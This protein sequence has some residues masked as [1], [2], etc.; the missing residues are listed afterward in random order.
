MAATRN[1]VYDALMALLAGRLVPATVKTVT[2]RLQGWATTPPA[3]RP[4]LFISELTE[5][6]ARRPGEPPRRAW[7]AVVTCVVKTSTDPK[8]AT[9]IALNDVMDQVE[10]AFRPSQPGGRQTLDGLAWDCR[11]VGTNTIHEG[12][13]DGGDTTAE[14][15]VEILMDDDLD[16]SDRGFVF[17]AGALYAGPLTRQG[18]DAIAPTAPARLGAVQDVEVRA[19]SELVMRDSGLQWAI[20]ASSTIRRLRLRA[21]FAQID[22]LVADQLLAGS[23]SAPRASGWTRCTRSAPRRTSARSRR[24]T[25][26][27]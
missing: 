19:D 18:G 15:A 23:Q 10:G 3:N 16:R 22:G 4:A 8:T 6:P 27:R 13:I 21:R 9:S 20:A 11:V 12:D 5:N 2:R 17:G 25:A 1:Q 26:S 24:S 14:L 7:Y